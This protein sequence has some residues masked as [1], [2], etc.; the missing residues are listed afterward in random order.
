MATLLIPFSSFEVASAADPTP[1][2]SKW[3]GYVGGGGESLLTYDVLTN[4]GG[5][6]I[7]HAGGSVAPNSGGRVSCLNGRTG[8]A[9][10]T[11]TIPN[12][13]DTCQIHLV[14]MDND[15]RM[16][17]V[18]PLQMPAGIYILNAEDGTTQFSDTTL[19]GGRIDSSPVSGDVDGD[20]YPDL[21]LGVMAYET[22]P[23]TGKIIHY[24]FNGASIVERQRVQV[25][26]PC[27]GGLALCDTDNDGRVELYM[28][29][30]DVYF[31]DG[32][33]GRGTV[34]FWADTLEVRWQLY[35]WGASSNI[36]MLADVNK[37]DVIDVVTTDLSRSVCVLNS[38]DG[39][40]LMNSAVTVLYGSG[41]GERRN[42]YQS[43][44]YDFD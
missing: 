19:G 43:S 13:G 38:T 44:I 24:E 5:E 25:W 39:K 21:Y 15:G 35:D 31:G 12:V 40:P 22:Q 8:A 17:L 33:W 6:E 3:T 29:E 34:S 37:D 36:P 7:F 11:R 32:G 18:V 1:L 23:S 20:G 9:I 42:H 2:T 14:D 28:N 30:R 10:W 26:H 4:I 27:A 41:S 16:E